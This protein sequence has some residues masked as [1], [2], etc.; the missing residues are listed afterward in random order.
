MKMWRG[1]V[2]CIARHIGREQGCCGLPTV[3]HGA[4]Q[5]N[6]GADRIDWDQ[7]ISV[8]FAEPMLE[9]IGRKAFWLCARHNES[10]SEWA[11]R[12]MLC[13]I[14][15][16]F[17][18]WPVAIAAASVRTARRAAH[19]AGRAVFRPRL[20]PFAVGAGVILA[21]VFLLS[22]DPYWTRSRA[23]SWDLAFRHFCLFVAPATN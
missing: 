20:L 22:I 10:D 9:L 18:A 13:C 4:I 23:K 1:R 6:C 8:I 12:Y 2:A 19:A 17:L 21:C 3:R 7:P 14:L 16:A 11:D 15:I 5:S